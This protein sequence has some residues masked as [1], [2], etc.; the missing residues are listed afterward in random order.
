MSNTTLLKPVLTEKSLNKADLYVFKVDPQ[1]NKNQIKETV[2]KVYK[3]V[4]SEIK[5]V[6]VKGK[7][8]VAGKRRLKK[9]LSKVKKAYIT[10]SKGKIDDFPKNN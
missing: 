8:K 9:R 1:A 10:L 7:M 2:E 3:V 5:T 6:V 4:V